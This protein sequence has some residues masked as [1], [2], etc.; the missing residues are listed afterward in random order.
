MVVHSFTGI[1]EYISEIEQFCVIQENLEG[2]T[3]QY[4]P[5]PGFSPEVLT[6]TKAK[7]LNLLQEPFNIKFEAVD[8]IPS[9][10][11]GKPQIIISK[12]S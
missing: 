5:G 9:T 8:Y 12:L 1:F 2:I 3:I 4:I 7:I 6:S 10:P 11:S